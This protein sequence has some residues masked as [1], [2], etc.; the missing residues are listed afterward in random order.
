MYSKLFA[1]LL[2]SVPHLS[3]AAGKKLV[4]KEGS[5]CVVEI[6]KGGEELGLSVAKCERT[7]SA[8]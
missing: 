3:F 4:V 1:I 8:C 5:P 7:V 2:L 6:P